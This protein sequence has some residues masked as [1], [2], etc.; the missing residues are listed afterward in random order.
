MALEGQTVRAAGA[1][2]RH[3][4]RGGRVKSEW[5]Q[6]YLRMFFGKQARHMRAL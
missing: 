4:R 3:D 5:R 6:G 1:E 2:Q